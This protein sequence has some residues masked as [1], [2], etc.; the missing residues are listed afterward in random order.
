MTEPASKPVEY[1]RDYFTGSVLPWGDP[2]F[3]C[4]T[5]NRIYDFEW[6]VEQERVALTLAGHIW[7]CEQLL[8][9]P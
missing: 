9:E 8:P 4:R 2:R 3:V 6:P 7:E 1:V 5:C